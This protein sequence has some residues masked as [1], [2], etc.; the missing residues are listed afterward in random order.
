M[1]TNEESKPSQ[2]VSPGMAPEASSQ[3]TGN[4]VV[5]IVAPAEPIKEEAGAPHPSP[6]EATPSD[7]APFAFSISQLQ[8]LLDP[9][10][11][12]LLK[13]LGGLRGIIRGLHT[14]ATLGLD[15]RE[16]THLPPV[17]IQDILQEN[18]TSGVNSS[19]VEKETRVDVGAVAA[20]SDLSEK[21]NGNSSPS[22]VAET[23]P[24]AFVER[25]RVY[26]TNRLPT[27]KT[28]NIFQLMW[29]AYQEKILIL[30]TVAALVSLAL[31]IY[32]DVSTP[33]EIQHVSSDGTS[34]TEYSPDVRWVE[35]F[36]IIVAIAIVVLV[37]SLNDYQKEKQFQKLNA[38][39]EDRL[40]RVTRGGVQ[41]YISIHDLLVGDVV[42]IEPGDIIAA[43]GVFISGHNLKCDESAATGESDAVRKLD[44]EECYRRY[45]ASLYEDD[46][47]SVSDVSAL[48]PDGLRGP[49]LL[50][51][52]DQDPTGN[53]MPPS[54]ADARRLDAHGKRSLERTHVP[55]ARAHSL[56]DPFLLSGSKVLE[57]VGSYVVIAV[58]VHSFH[59]K[60]MM[61]LRQENEGTP[62]QAKLNDLA[63]KIAKF[64][65]AASLTML[66]VLLIK[67]FVSFRYGVPT[68]T[69]AV[70]NVVQIIISTITVIVVAIPEGLPLAVTLALA[71]A[72]TRMLRDNNLVRVL[73]AC[74]TMGNATT[75]CSDKTGTL[76]Q[77]RMT[78][79]AG[80]IG[81][82]LRF[83]ADPTEE[84]ERRMA[85]YRRSTGLLSKSESDTQATQPSAGGG[86]TMMSREETEIS[87]TYLKGGKP[88]G[89]VPPPRKI[90]AIKD[91][92]KATPSTT[93]NLLH[94]NICINSTAFESTDDRGQPAFVGN[95]TETALLG[96]SKDIG[97][98]N[99]EE[100]RNR[101]PV[102]QVFPFS[103]DRKA[104]ATVVEIPSDGENKKVYRMFVKGAS[105]VILS[106]S[107]R[108][109]ETTS[110]A[111]SS[112]TEQPEIVPISAEINK[113]LQKIIVSYATKSL[114]TI[115][116]A[117][118]DFE[119]W[120]PV[121]T[122]SQPLRLEIPVPGA[123]T[124]EADAEREDGDKDE[125][126]YEDLV[127]AE[128]GLVLQAIVGI[129]DPLREG[130]TDAVRRCQ[131]A[132][133]FVRMVTGDNILTAKS[134]ARQCGIY[135]QGGLI[136]EG[137]TFRQLSSEEMDRV[138]PRLQV[139]ARSSP[140][141]KRILVSKLKEMNEVVAVTGDGTNDGPALK[142]ADIGF[143]MG[144]AGTEVAKEAS[145][146]ILMDDNFS[147]IVK[148]V[149]WGR[150]VNDSVKKFLQF[151][152]TVNVTA[153]LL[154]FISA[155]S[156]NEEKAAL[157]PVQ[158][159]WVNLIMDTFAALALATDP[160]TDEILKRQPESR[161]GPLISIP[162]WK[163]ILG[164]SLYQLAV[165]LILLYAGRSIM[166]YQ[167]SAV[168]EKRLRTLVFNT[169][170][171]C[172]IFNELNCRNLGNELNVFRGIHRNIY[173][174]SIFFIM[175]LGQV[176]ITQFG[177]PAFQ[178]YGLGG[179]EWAVSI[180][181]GAIS[182]VVGV[183]LRLIPD[184]LI[185]FIFKL[186]GVNFKPLYVKPRVTYKANNKQ[187]EWQSPITQVR[188]ELS[189]FKS[190]RG[191][192]LQGISHGKPETSH[193][194]AAMLPSLVATS[195]GASIHDE[196]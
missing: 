74:E 138:I 128:G 18:T 145:S 194:A 9:K 49:P 106:K 151:Q 22:K 30:L 21:L 52:P 186:F 83:T 37:G 3:D 175:V 53:L 118:R 176:L 154:T 180:V 141:D 11:I 190:V 80:T 187:I 192:R 188:N 107:Q 181:V 96:F 51:L 193:L 4:H 147:S 42:H 143:S 34:S 153:V 161:R 105:E 150:S 31:G 183:I 39:K 87:L 64:G 165:T 139:L 164:Q 84:N 115:G 182:L 77:N 88:R 124:T 73:A 179:I 82:Y 17:S 160:P 90:E 117:Y 103:S 137:P 75:I 26:G 97:I 32:E 68:A 135:T 56:P 142:M 19:E 33:N 170:V 8:N 94:E 29:A 14:N 81:A 100:I 189:V 28:K 101:Y 157:T 85:A 66:L 111:T 65:L 47:R 35:G 166:L 46:A 50:P 123:P 130:V 171:F 60:T 59:G 114:R 48:S 129:E 1:S 113:R 62:L 67:F 57:G 149:M 5:N 7:T 148:A 43:D 6:S 155:A 173:F 54:T 89:N 184:E 133:I 76:T 159:L 92:S 169:F 63:E 86:S 172:Q 70:D 41:S 71:F 78:V 163:M 196:K 116:I 58:G 122:P 152:L 191:G 79:V 24:D 45:E 126:K 109:V 36:A 108:I 195:V 13:D 15:V 178:T 119:S 61:A 25:K 167:D 95:K 185:E 72:T 156:S 132:G 98:G 144:I 27:K 174:I 125:V 110:T 112:Q 131:N 136:M 177:G 44:W 168:D 120:P 121:P 69:A 55:A 10:N 146:I 127:N 91:L 134:I 2:E 162:M 158:L 102:V 20:A 93:L 40:V 38:K 104:M 23:S 140:E 16:P 99:Y 12:Q